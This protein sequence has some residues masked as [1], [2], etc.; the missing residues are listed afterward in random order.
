MTITKQI[1]VIIFIVVFSVVIYVIELF[2]TLLLT[3]A[4]FH[5]LGLP[6]KG[7]STSHSARPIHQN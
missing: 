4:I 7:N 2:I 6:E 1:V 5:D 3:I